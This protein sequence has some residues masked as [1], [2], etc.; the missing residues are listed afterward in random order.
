MKKF[1]AV[2]ITALLGLALVFFWL[3]TFEAVACPRINA[4]PY[5]SS[6]GS[7]ITIPIGFSEEDLQHVG[8]KVGAEIKA[9]RAVLKH[10]TRSNGYLALSSICGTIGGFL[11]FILMKKSNRQVP[12]PIMPG[13]S[14]GS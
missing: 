1:S 7:W 2:F 4:N 6:D 8:I 9:L 5:I 13:T 10:I 3:G 14:R 12:P 11:S